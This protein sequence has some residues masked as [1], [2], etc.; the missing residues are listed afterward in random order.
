V[1]TPDT[2]RAFAAAEAAYLEPPEVCP[3]CEGFGDDCVDGEVC[4][5]CR[6]SDGDAGDWD[7]HE[8]EMNRDARE[9]RAGL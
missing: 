4:R 8:W 2:A 3:V 7:E 6:A 1:T 9:A 5:Y